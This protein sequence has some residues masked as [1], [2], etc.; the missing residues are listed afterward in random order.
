MTGR[1]G[2]TDRAGATTL[3]GGGTIRVLIADDDEAV[4][5]TLARLV[6]RSDGLVLAGAATSGDEAISLGLAL[7][8]DVAL[9]DVSMPGRDGI[10]VTEA[11]RAGSP[12]TRVVALSGSA[13]RAEVLGMLAAGASGY[14]L[15]GATTDLVAALRAA[16]RGEGVLAGEI[17]SEVIGEL[18]TRLS[19]QRE[20]E[21]ERHLRA[22]RVRDAID[23][24]LHMAFQPVMTLDTGRIAGHE[25][26]ARFRT[27]PARPPDQWFAEAW[28]VGMGFE[29]ELAAFQQAVATAARVAGTRLV[30]VN[31]SPGVLTDPRFA[32]QMET[33]P[34][35]D[36]LVLEVTEHAVV[37]DYGPL[38]RALHRYRAAGAR[39]AVDDAGAG[40]AS[41]RHVLILRPDL[42][43]L[44][45]SLVTGIHEDQAKRAVA[46]GII[47]SASELGATVVAEGIEE[48][49]ELRCVAG[50]GARLGQGYLLGRPSPLGPA[51]YPA[52]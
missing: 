35:A 20:D 40:Y 6:A 11:L 41:L 33:C 12:A 49:A 18:S 15:K 30:S 17:A 42:V 45:R 36:R 1:G 43:K 3:E 13:E 16:G 22:A 24:G 39:V 8:P 46:V 26:L 27:G 9:I 25:A 48:E 19:R 51:L 4:R 21:Q 7:Q 31:L 23:G 52:G 38:V 28:S 50:L 14:L 32:A 34:L 29:L 10:K 5:R 47:S 2:T 37:D 44:D